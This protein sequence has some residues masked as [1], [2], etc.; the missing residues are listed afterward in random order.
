MKH[1]EHPMLE[2]DECVASDT[3]NL[4]ERVILKTSAFI[5]TVLILVFGC[6]TATCAAQLDRALLD[7]ILKRQTAYFKSI[8]SVEFK[9]S[10]STFFNNAL[11]KQVD[12]PVNRI[13][14]YFYFAMSGTNYLS[15]LN[16]LDLKTKN[17]CAVTVAY[18]GQLYQNLENSFL[19]LGTKGNSP[20]PY[21]TMLPLFVPFLWALPPSDAATFESFRKPDRFTSL[22]SSASVLRKA[23]YLGHKGYEV[24]FTRQDS[25]GKA[26]DYWVFFAKDMGYY[27]LRQQTIVAGQ[28]TSET[29]ILKILSSDGKIPIPISIIAIGLDKAK[30]FKQTV[31]FKVD[32]RSLK[33][34]HKLS[35]EKFTIPFS[36][37]E[38]VYDCDKERLLKKPEPKGNLKV[39]EKA[40]DFTLKDIDGNDF[41]FSAFLQSHSKPVV[42][43]IWATWCG[44]CRRLSPYLM[45]LQDKYKDKG[46]NVIGIALDEKSA[47]VKSYIQQNNVSYTILS[48]PR[49]NTL[50]SSYKIESIPA[51]YVIDSNGV[52]KYAQSGFP[53]SKEDAEKQIAD[54]VR[55]VEDSLTVN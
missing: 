6:Y 48:D 17:K 34:N 2:N 18:N 33:V 21:Y 20:V 47:D 27:P 4:F 36:L 26:T 31:C 39:G 16:Y 29:R 41:A 25:M 9:H 1:N 45:Q 35:K 30:G 24:K 38:R 14:Q 46:V 32:P 3:R 7:K 10:H 5:F 42:L 44:P 12:V 13:D 53:I 54:I 28:Q 22:A 49:G 37:A 23:E 55:G 11:R 50:G 43:D 8:D 52:V 19:A 51:I 15:K 40:P